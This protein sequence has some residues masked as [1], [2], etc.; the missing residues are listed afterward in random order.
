M[1][2]FH[3]APATDETYQLAEG[4]VWDQ[5]RERVLWV[6]IDA[7]EVLTGELHEGRVR[8]T[9]RQAF[10]E[11]VGAA[12]CSA[13]GQLLVARR[14]D[15]LVVASGRSVPV[16]PAD[17]AS[18]FNDGACD[19]AG[20]FVVGS[21]ALDGRTKD[22]ALYRL[23]HDG[24][25][26]VLDDDLTLSNGL[27]WSPDG[28]RMYS[29]DTKPGTVWVRDY[30]PGSGSGSG[31]R[32]QLLGISDGSPDGMCVDTDGNLWI[33]IW[34]AGEVRCYTPGGD[35]IAIV[36]VGPPHTSSVEFVGPDLDRLLITTATSEL[37]PAQLDEFPDSGRL[38]TAR[39]GARGLPSTPWSPLV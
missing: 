37:G 9:V 7:G 24:G 36:H 5:A 14:R 23:E 28:A 27:A 21:M 38:F 4:P 17:K 18:R 34:G 6:D 26:T 10:G 31:T 22:D 20:R 15:L 35:Q 39:V 33:A 11:T 29:I 19:P 30:D 2:T 12:V 32:T 13:D 25:V 1:Q 16:I 8:R 3:A